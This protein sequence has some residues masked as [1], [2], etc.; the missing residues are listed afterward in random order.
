MNIPYVFAFRPVSVLDE[1]EDEAVHSSPDLDWT[2]VDTDEAEEIPDEPPSSE[3]NV[4]LV[5]DGD[6]EII[7]GGGDF[8]Q[9]DVASHI[10]SIAVCKDGCV[11]RTGRRFLGRY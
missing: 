11:R 6:E 1:E 5:G 2:H 7:V 9:G 3:V 8:D 10:L 4:N